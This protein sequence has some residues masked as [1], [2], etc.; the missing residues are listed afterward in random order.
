MY[1]CICKAVSDRTIKGIIQSG[2][3][4]VDDVGRVCGAGTHCGGCRHAVQELISRTVH[5]GPAQSQQ[6]SQN[7]GSRG[8]HL[9][10][11]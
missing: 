5:S 2:A 1:I 9:A 11:E 3:R 10:A 4:S 6:E 8:G 7:E